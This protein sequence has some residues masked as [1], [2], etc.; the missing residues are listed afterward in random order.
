MDSE[1]SINDSGF[2][3]PGLG[4]TVLCLHTATDQEEALSWQRQSWLGAEIDSWYCVSNWNREW[5]LPGRD[6]P[7][8]ESRERFLV[9][10][11]LIEQYQELE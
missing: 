2:T 10:F 1:V 11:V 5:G 3:R 7:E 9:W 4:E 8:R 6:S